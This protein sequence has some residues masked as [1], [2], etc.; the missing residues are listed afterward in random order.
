MDQMKL[1][2]YSVEQGRKETNWWAELTI[3]K[4]LELKGKENWTEEEREKVA[5][6]GAQAGGWVTCA[7]GNQCSIIPRTSNG[8]PYDG[9]L[10]SL[11]IEFSE[12]VSYHNLRVNRAV[13]VLEKIEKRS[14]YLIKEIL[15]NGKSSTK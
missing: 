8:S 12:Y 7:C 11:G 5:D 10:C 2:P 14:E 3:L 15:K 13:D 4:E 6:L 1:K 9:E